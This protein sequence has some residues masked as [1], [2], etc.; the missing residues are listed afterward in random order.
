MSECKEF[1]AR[2]KTC[3]SSARNLS[4]GLLHLDLT[5]YSLWARVRRCYLL[6]TPCRHLNLG[7]ILPFHFPTAYIRP[8]H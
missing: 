1:E 2:Y 5:S 7:L 4:F 8:L 3:V 6:L